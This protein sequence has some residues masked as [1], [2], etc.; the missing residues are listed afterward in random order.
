MNCEMSFDRIKN[1]VNQNVDADFLSKCD[2]NT[3]T[4]EP[5]GGTSDCKKPIRR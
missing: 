1:L 5:G 3:Q 4:C 2:G